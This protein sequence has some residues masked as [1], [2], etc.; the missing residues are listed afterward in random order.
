[1]PFVAV[2]K[3]AIK[4]RVIGL[5]FALTPEVP[6]TSQ[7]TEHILNESSMDAKNYD[8][9]FPKLYWIP[10]RVDAVILSLASI[11]PKSLTS[12]LTPLRIDVL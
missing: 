9:K 7:C 6:L 5:R 10:E 3:L 2:E 11:T 4:S 12:G 1:M 8:V